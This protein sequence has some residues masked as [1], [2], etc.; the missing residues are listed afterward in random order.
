M[1]ATQSVSPQS[2]KQ[3]P[4]PTTDKTDQLLAG[5]TP[6]MKLDEVEMYLKEAGRVPLLSRDEE[7]D[8]AQRIEAGREASRKLAEGDTQNS[9][10]L[11]SIIEDGARAREH[12]ILAN[13]RLV[14]SVAKKYQNLG[15]P[16]LDLIQEGNLGLMRAIK[17]FDYRRGY[18]FSTYATWWIRQAI[19]RSV[20]DKGRVIRLPVHVH[21]QLR[22]IRK[23]KQR[24]QHEL[25]REP[26]P[27]EIA[28]HVDISVA[29]IKELMRQT[30][31]SITLDTPDE[32][33]EDAALFERLADRDALQPLDLVNQHEKTESVRDLLGLLSPRE[34][35]ILRLRFG[36][37]GGTTHSLSAIGQKFELTRER[38][39]Q[40]EEAALEHLRRELRNQEK[41]IL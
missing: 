19:T 14:I 17:K 3:K 28:P 38:V 21:T 9:M 36:L 12:L 29:R 25:S 27:E 15:L 20:A 1:T 30:Q 11:K 16:L 18:K 10:A 23:A 37:Q 40:I 39:R 7:V 13:L 24:L 4:N 6:S 8:L 33:E 32:D 34:E 35:R 22:H 26:T 2:G 31:S 41:M 5:F